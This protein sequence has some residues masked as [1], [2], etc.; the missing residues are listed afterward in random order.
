MLPGPVSLKNTNL[1]GKNLDIE[2]R[3]EH[4]RKLSRS[5]AV[6]QDNRD[7]ALSGNWSGYREDH[8][9]PDWLLI[10]RIE[11]E[12]PI[13]TLTRTATHSDLFKNCDLPKNR[14]FPA[15]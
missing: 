15:A 1:P 10:Y 12:L 5:E 8:V 3:A 13:L 11:E 7:Q 14:Q 6:P 9:Q 2:L 4:I